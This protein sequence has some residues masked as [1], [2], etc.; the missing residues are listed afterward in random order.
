MRKQSIAFEF[1]EHEDY[2]SCFLGVQE[3]NTLISGG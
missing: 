2:V 3:K 1:Q